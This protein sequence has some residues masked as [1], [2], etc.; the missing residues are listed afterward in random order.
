MDRTL[1]K[2]TKLPRLRSIAICFWGFWCGAPWLEAMTRCAVLRQEQLA[3]GATRRRNAAKLW[4][5]VLNLFSHYLLLDRKT[6]VYDVIVSG[7]V[8]GPN[9]E[10]ELEGRKQAA[11]SKAEVLAARRNAFGTR[12]AAY[13]EDVAD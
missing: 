3:P 10:G 2:G 8:S 13:R 4:R 6:D 7:A 11:K 5:L 1:S 9:P 12:F